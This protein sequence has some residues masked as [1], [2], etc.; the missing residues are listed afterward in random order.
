MLSYWSVDT[1]ERGRAVW[2]FAAPGCAEQCGVE[3][4]GPEHLELA[5]SE[6]TLAVG[7]TEGEVG[8]WAVEVPIEIRQE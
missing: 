2:L 4:I 3:P 6:L 8:H 7:H 5:A 1:V